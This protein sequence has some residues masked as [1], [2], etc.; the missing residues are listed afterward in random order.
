MA[1]KVKCVECGSTRTWK[2][3]SVPSR[4]G[5]KRKMAVRLTKMSKTRQYLA[6]GV[7]MKP[8]DFKGRK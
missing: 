7:S 5:P 6:Y 3:G 4:S 1:D 2:K 8:T